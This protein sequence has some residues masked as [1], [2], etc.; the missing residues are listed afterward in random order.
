MRE[1]GEIVRVAGAAETSPFLINCIGK[2]AEFAA[3]AISDLVREEGID[4]VIVDY[5]QR[6]KTERRLQDRRNEVTYATATISDAIKISG[7]AGMLLSQLK[8]LQDG[9]KPTNEDLKESGDIEC[10]AENI[11]LG[12]REFQ[13]GGTEE[14]FCILSK[15]KDG[16]VILDPIKLDW[17]PVSAC[18]NATEA[19]HPAD[20]G[21][22]RDFHHLNED[23]DAAIAD[24]Y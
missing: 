8:R 19:S 6:I 17:N 11:I 3:Q 21:K 4:L 1:R 5:L 7:A 15:A 13:P 20:A 23:L 10:F 22:D 18:F 14:K 24:R 16:Q 12:W 9:K 2:T